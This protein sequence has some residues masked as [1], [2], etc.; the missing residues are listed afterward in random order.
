MANFY[1]KTLIWFGMFFVAIAN[2]AIRELVIKLAL[3]D[4]WA[5]HLSAI[6]AIILFTF[7]LTLVWNSARIDSYKSAFLTGW[8]WLALTLVTETILLGRLFSKL[9][10]S[11]IADSYDIRKSLWLVVILWVGAVPSILY[12]FIGPSGSRKR[13]SI[14][15][16]DQIW[17]Q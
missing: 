7:Y 13:I 5:H 10:W 4:P 1:R 3:S 16:L 12:K 11:E 2:G 14:W 9:T 15:R 6:T 17:S 8:Y